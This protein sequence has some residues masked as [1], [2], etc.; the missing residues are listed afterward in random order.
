MKEKGN[1]FTDIS[2]LPASVKPAS[3]GG[4][5]SG[6]CMVLFFSTM[7]ESLFSLDERMRENSTYDIVNDL[8]AENS[9]K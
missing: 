5:G 7:A 3:S 1:R 6:F 9:T 4:S 8:G 2:L